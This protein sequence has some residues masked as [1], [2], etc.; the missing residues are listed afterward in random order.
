[1]KNPQK[2]NLIPRPPIVVVMGHIDHGKTTLLDYIRKT[3]VTESESGGITQHVSAYEIELRIKN[4]ELRKVTFLDTPGHEAFSKIRER[5]AKIAD[6][7]ILVIAADDKVNAQTKEALEVV[8]KTNISFVIAVNK[9][10]KEN[11]NPEKIKTELS[12]CDTQ[13]EEWGGKIPCI[14]ISAQN[15]KGID[16]L[17]EM[18]LLLADLEELKT[19]PDANASGF[20]V[21]SHIDKKRGIA[22]T[23]IIQNG[24]L[25][26]GMC[27]ATAAENEAG[28][29]SPVRILED[30]SG[31]P[32]KEAGASSPVKI[33]GFNKT[34]P[35]GAEFKS[36]VCRKDVPI[37]QKSKTSI[38]K[39]RIPTPSETVVE[40][41]PTEK[42]IIPIIIKAD[43]SSSVEALEKIIERL[44]S[45]KISIKIL[46]AEVGDINE[47]DIKLATNGKDTIIVGFHIKDQSPRSNILIKLF[48]IIYEAEEWLAE[49]IKKREP[50]E[51]REEI[52]GK[53][54]ILKI[55]K[56][57]KTKKI[58][59]GQVISGKIILGK[60]VKIYRRDLM[61]GEG[62]IIELQHN[63]IK[64]EEVP[65]SEQFGALLQTKIVIAPK[66]TLEIYD[67]A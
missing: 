67:K 26:Q 20:V 35:P 48:D 21:E 59:G 8:K 57:E 4:H 58:I 11:A 40:A 47:N 10:D 43:M 32:I 42:T 31:K 38:E 44:S 50:V 66:D 54:K 16:E 27:I 12:E 13:I 24:T 29:I 7:A 6:V 52:T 18:V 25:K 30:F 2:N 19:D 51:V 1:M 34:P 56:D 65:E 3:K 22:A 55:F 9:I 41:E 49:E 45:E 14:E 33:L 39:S 28:A 64:A 61:L 23:L 5:G 63:K 62:K 17:L 60:K 53:A 46:R 15:G 36:F 37:F